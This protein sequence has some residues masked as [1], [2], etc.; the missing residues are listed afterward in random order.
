M[1]QNHFQGY[2][3]ILID[4]YLALSFSEEFPHAVGTN[5][6][7][8]SQPDIMHGMTDLGHSAMNNE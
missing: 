4:Q 7:R 6:D 8:E 2:S 3:A 1:L 5:K